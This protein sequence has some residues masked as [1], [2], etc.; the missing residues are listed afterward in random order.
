M[1]NKQLKLAQRR[2]LLIEQ[3]AYQRTLLSV[4]VE[5]LQSPL[6]IADKGVRVYRYLTRKPVLLAGAAALVAA[7]R[8]KRW[9]VLFEN[10]MLI[11][12]LV[13]AARRGFK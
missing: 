1:N 3:I 9:L 2:A 7:T 11:W 10:G 12:Q 4:A 6:R 5:P 13:S 8:P